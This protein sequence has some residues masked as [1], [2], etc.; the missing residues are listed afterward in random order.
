MP[1][2]DSV[3]CDEK[4]KK[5]NVRTSVFE[6]CEGDCVGKLASYCKKKCKG[7]IRDS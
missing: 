4:P 5:F 3:F 2:E 7:G 1:V 6:L